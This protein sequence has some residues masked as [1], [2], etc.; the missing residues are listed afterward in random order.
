M[1]AHFLY[2]LMLFEINSLHLSD[3][4]CS[5]LQC[6]LHNS[7][8]LAPLYPVWKCLPLRHSRVKT[9]AWGQGTYCSGHQA[10]APVLSMCPSSQISAGP[11]HFHHWSAL[12]QGTNPVPQEEAVPC[13]WSSQSFAGV[14]WFLLY[15]LW[16]REA[17]LQR[18]SSS[19][20]HQ[21]D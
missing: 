8:I 2:S 11:P 1:A 12:L 17:E 6:P 14:F 19:Q 13:L 7:R 9:C 3:F 5:E 16:D 20:A 4:F 18:L 21:H 10:L 15:S